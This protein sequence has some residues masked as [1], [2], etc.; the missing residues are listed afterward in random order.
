MEDAATTKGEEGILWKIQFDIN[1][2]IHCFRHSVR[3]MKCV[4]SSSLYLVAVELQLRI[5]HAHHL[6]VP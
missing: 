5:L 4:P 1:W 2:F 3:L 6:Q